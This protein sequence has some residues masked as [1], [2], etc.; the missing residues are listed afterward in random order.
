MHPAA[1]RIIANVGHG[2]LGSACWNLESGALS[3]FNEAFLSFADL[4]LPDAVASVP[5]IWRDLLSGS[6]CIFLTEA[7][8]Q[9]VLA[10]TNLLIDVENSFRLGQITT[11]TAN[12]NFVT[13][14]GR[15]KVPL[16]SWC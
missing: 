7:T 15:Q 5:P 6:N 9:H 14:I 11:R 16:Q 13:R 1:A 12:M 10:S 4:R 3:S 2:S 8:K